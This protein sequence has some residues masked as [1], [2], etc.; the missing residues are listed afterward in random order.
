MIQP[1][2]IA[3][4]V[5]AI[6][7]KNKDINFLSEVVPKLKKYY[8][9]L[10]ENR[11]PDKDGLISIISPYEAGM[12]QSSSFDPVMEIEGKHALLMS[13]AGRKITFKNMMRNYNLE[14]IFAADYFNVEDVLVNSIYIY[15]LKILIKLLHEIDMEKDARWFMQKYNLAKSSLLEKCFDK[16]RKVFFDLYSK[17]EKVSKILTI[18]SLMPLILDIDKKYADRLVKEHLLNNDEFDL[19]YPVPTVARSEP[20]FLPA[21][22]VIAREPI[23]WRGPTWINTNWYLVKGLQNH[24][25]DVEAKKLIERTLD[26]IKQS[27]FREFFNPYTG[28]G[29]GAHNFS[30]STL[31]VDMVL[32]D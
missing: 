26:L 3:Q 11:D 1:P 27:G 29:Y 19:A 17:E 14:R 13:L 20:S 7:K 25:F 21:P 16:D 28:Q 4:S 2:L 12:D 9:W 6:Y 18:K 15:N 30:W 31:V 5:E 32:Q 10:A 24:G 8:T 23:I 22:P